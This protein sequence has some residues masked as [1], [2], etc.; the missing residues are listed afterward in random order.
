M[1]GLAQA[2]DRHGLALQVPDGADALGPE[3]LEAAAVDACQDDD[4]ITRVETDDERGGKMK[5][6]VDV[7]CRERLLLTD[8]SRFLDVLDVCESLGP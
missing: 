3:Q 8:V 7:T 2:E 6:Q 4:R 1:L 5:G